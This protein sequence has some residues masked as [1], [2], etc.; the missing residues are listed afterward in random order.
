M[1]VQYFL[2]KILITYYYKERVRHNDVINR[3]ALT[4]VKYGGVIFLVFGAA[5]LAPNKCAIEFSQNK[6]L[7]YSNEILSCG[8]IFWWAP[9]VML[10]LAALLLVTIFLI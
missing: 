8:K 3:T 5:A 10:G 9:L 1:T 6:V 2:D 7:H 4:I